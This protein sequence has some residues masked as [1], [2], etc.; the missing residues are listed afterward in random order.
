MET[1]KQKKIRRGTGGKV[2]CRSRGGAD[3]VQKGGNSEVKKVIVDK[4]T[5]CLI[6]SMIPNP[7]P[8]PSNG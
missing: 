7:G 6:P 3:T 4:V 8:S 5:R 2:K 1:L